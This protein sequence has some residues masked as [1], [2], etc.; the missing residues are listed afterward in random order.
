MHGA[1]AL[2]R[3]EAAANQGNVTV[4]IHR[5]VGRVGEV[6]EF[7]ALKGCDLDIEQG[8][9]MPVL[10]GK[11]RAHRRRGARFHVRLQTSQLVMERIETLLQNQ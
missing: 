10:T 6:G 1:R 3:T 5:L 8:G 11:P 7:L 2:N 9:Q 4:Q